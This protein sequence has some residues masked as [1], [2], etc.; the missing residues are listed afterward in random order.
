MHAGKKSN[1][2]G[3]SP[4]NDLVSF[5]RKVA[6]VYQ[7]HHTI[8]AFLRTGCH[9]GLC[10]CT[11]TTTATDRLPGLALVAVRQPLRHIGWTFPFLHCKAVT[12][13]KRPYHDVKQPGS[14]VP[15]VPADSAL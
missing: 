5:S 8:F 14:K 6:H 10:A 7:D 9:D 13:S 15:C 4:A 1:R 11:G 3:H 2:I 12:K